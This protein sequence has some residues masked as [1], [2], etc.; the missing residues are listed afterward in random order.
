[1]GS[2]EPSLLGQ[3]R[4]HQLHHTGLAQAVSSSLSPRPQPSSSW[5]PPQLP[6]GLVQLEGS[7]DDGDEKVRLSVSRAP[8]CLQA[9][10]AHKEGE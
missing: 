7:V 3:A 8:N 10:V 2:Q 9:S 6:G 5:P 4:T 1:M